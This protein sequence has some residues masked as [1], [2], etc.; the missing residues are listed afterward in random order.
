[1]VEVGTLFEIEGFVG[2]FILA[3]WLYCIF[4]VITTNESLVRNLPKGVWIF[5]V[6]FLFEIGAIAWL[7]LG[8]PQMA[9]WRPGQTSYGSAPKQR[10]P[11]GPDDRIGTTGF[12]AADL[13]TAGMS[14][15]VRE[16]EEQARLK[17]W[18]TQLKRREDELRLRE[19]GAAPRAASA[20][21]EA[22]DPTAPNPWTTPGA[23]GP[24]APTV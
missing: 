21:A 4:D 7:I 19:L 24:E 8:R 16:R 18:K 15:I 22:T 11:L 5:L 23:T 10:R 6:I 1:M 17:V 13:D 12:P 20:A 14:D 2:L 9:G 3:L